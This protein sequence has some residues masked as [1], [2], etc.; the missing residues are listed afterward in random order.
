MSH[1]CPTKSFAGHLSHSGLPKRESQSRVLALLL[2][3]TIGGLL[4]ASYGPPLP[5]PL[6]W[7]SLLAVVWLLLR[8]SRLATVILA[9]FCALLAAAQYQRQLAPPLPTH[10]VARLPQGQPLTIQGRV[11]TINGG[12]G[13]L[14]IDL[15]AERLQNDP[16]RKVLTGLLRL[17]IGAG[18]PQLQVGQHIRFR[19]KLRTPEPFGTPG[20]F[21]YGRYLAARNIYVTTYL[22]RA[23]A[24]V[25]F[26]VEKESGL[27]AQVAA[28]RRAIGQRIDLAVEPERAALVRALV[29]GDR[30]LS[31]TQRQQL[32]ETGLSHLFAISGLHLGL[33]AL[34]LYTTGRWLYRRS[35]RLLLLIPPGRLLP[36][37]LLPLLWLYLQ[38]TGNALSTR[39]AFFMAVVGALLLLAGRRTRPLQALASVALVMLC[40]A[41]LSLF[42]PAWQLSMAGV[43]GILLLL[44]T[45]Q[46]TIATLPRLWCWPAGL[47]A[48]TLAATIATTPLV[49]S[50]FHLLATAGLLNNLLAV[51]LIGFAAVPLGLSGALLDP[52]W[53]TAGA[54]LY[55][56]C[57][58]ICQLTLQGAAQL[59]EVPLLSARVCYVSPRIL[60]GVT[61][62]SLLLL[63]PRW[64]GRW[65]CL[66]GA[67]L[68]AALL[69]LF[70]P[71]KTPQALTITA[72]SV[73]QGE[74]LLLSRPK[75]GH[76]LIDG[77]GLY[78]S[79]FDVGARLVAPALA[80]LGVSSLEAVILTHDHPDHRQGLVEVLNHFPVKA[81]WSAQT[82]A[83]L[84]PEI[85][86]PLQRH[87]I[88]LRTFAAGWT[89]LEKGTT[90]EL[91]IY[92]PS[93]QAAKVNDRSLVLYA[94][95]GQDGLLLTGDLEQQGVVN[96]LANP[97]DGPV[98]LL[99]LPHHGSRYSEPWRLVEKLRPR[100][101]FTSTGRNNSYGLPHKI[102]TE[103]MT[104]AGLSL[105]DTGR[106]GSLRFSSDGSGWH[107]Q[108][109]Q[110]G[111]FR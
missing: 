64:T 4:A 108:S 39:R 33:L 111:L 58:Q 55:R 70:L 38:L 17:T 75:T 91:A 34:L 109:W 47:A 100:L 69:L 105:Y 25:P 81:F 21:N 51:P 15:E 28:L 104:T 88:P 83:E 50:H 85:R 76:Y 56:L 66:R 14:R 63:V 22:D 41:P 29:I 98:T 107:L 86:E 1:P 45:W 5:L 52:L 82:L 10:H 72:L 37:V 71:Q 48:T 30:Q 78:G 95:Q 11:K 99:K 7:P 26:A 16:N 79:T 74:A 84:H 90:G 46:R 35:E 80:R 61:I 12:S 89:P 3:S 96:L 67:L 92:R 36:I 23:E 106:D 13:N 87:A 103:S 8:N 42:E 18:D 53:P 102:V 97:P 57:G 59:S 62:L 94:R 27:L 110:K 2:L 60:T 73:G 6:L 65:L 101:V 44:P 49:L 32:A 54:A 93:Q 40:C 24:I 77:G 68:L 43:G 31:P 19:S 20:E 9:G